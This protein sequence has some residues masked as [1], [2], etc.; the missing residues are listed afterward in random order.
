MSK[1]VTFA[2]FSSKTVDELKKDLFELK[3]ALFNLR[4]R[5]AAKDVVDFSQFKKNRKSVA[6]IQTEMNRRVI[7]GGV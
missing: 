3:R 6:R 1:K 5:I 4:F 7:V 2:A